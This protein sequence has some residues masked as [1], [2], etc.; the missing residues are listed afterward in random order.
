MTHVLDSYAGNGVEVVVATPNEHSVDSLVFAV[1][2]ELR[3]FKR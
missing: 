2:N 3:Q 1:D